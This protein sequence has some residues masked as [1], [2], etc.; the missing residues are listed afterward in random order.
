MCGIAGT[1]WSAGVEPLAPAIL[2]AMTSAL[3]HRGPD[4][5]GHYLHHGDRWLWSH[6][7]TAGES[8]P[9][10]RPGPAG[11][12]LG[13]R[14]LSIIDLAGGHQPLA[15]EDRSVWI[16]FNGEIYNHRELQSELAARGHVF[17]TRSDTEVI[18]H[19]YEELGPR[20]VERLRG[21]FAF[22]IWSERDQSLL[23]AR[24][25][26][27]K[28]PLVYRRET[29]PGG[30]RLLFAS[31]LKALLQVPGVPRQVAPRAVL[32]YL[33]YQYVPHPTCILEGFQ[34][35][36]PGCLAIYRRGQLRVERYWQ[37]P[38][39]LLGTNH[40]GMTS[41]LEQECN[42]DGPAVNDSAQ[43]PFQT[44]GLDVEGSSQR[45]RPMAATAGGA[46]VP[47][48]SSLP[49]AQR[50][51]RETLTEAVRLRLRSDVPLGAFLSGGIDS[52]IIAGL[53][54]QLAGESVE[55][56][57]IGF[58]IPEFDERHHAREVATRLG[59]RHHELVLE[60]QALE[61]LPRLIWQYDEP[62]ADSSAIPT[63][64]LCELA[65]QH[66][67]VALSGDGGDELFAGYDRYRA[68]ELGRRFDR[69][70]AP[71]RWLLSNRLW[72]ALPASTRQKS[73][74]RRFKRLLSALRYPPE[75]RYLK[76]IAIFDD[77]RLPGL[78]SPELGGV[79]GAHDPAEFLLGAYQDCGQSDFVA[80]TACVDARTYLPCDI[81]YKVDI[82]SMAHSLEVRSPF[83]D[84]EVAALSS[85]IPIRWKRRGRQGKQILIDTFADLLPPGV[86]TR[87]KMGFG[88]PLDRWFRG[89]L[90]PLLEQ[91]LLDPRALRRGWF[92][93]AAI[94]Q[95]IAEHVEN[96]WDHSY[97]LWSLLVL[98]LWQQRF[99]DDLPV[100]PPRSSTAG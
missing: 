48:I 31:E 42:R 29:T 57:S 73:R 95:L 13:F 76:W 44:A 84:Q 98:E 49:E 21:M 23:L 97:R 17:R 70:P 66:V 32:D 41:A 20:C 4:D 18:I 87:P 46:A 9:S 26:L 91:V 94:R 51:V 24:D 99:V 58:T 3:V 50:L 89:E 54:R 83:L 11:C 27:G 25:R 35:L 47:A 14:R 19:L 100:P 77:E 39:E 8:L 2:Q 7:L 88:V 80:R 82:A 96:R 61:V 67:T 60:P 79:L 71:V 43:S 59:T 92:A 36:P 53:M 10:P 86:A 1:A 37:L 38:C 78:L 65:R 69:L 93:P 5:A 34:K 28:K 74:R 81:L 6:H 75:R 63:L 85:R 52:S 30:D 33:T 72:Q 45:N 64:A 16:V 22:A 90:R 40:V 55:T 15:N 62:F 68:V 56:F 12:A